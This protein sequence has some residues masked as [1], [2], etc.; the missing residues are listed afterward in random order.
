MATSGHG[1]RCSVMLWL[2]RSH[3]DPGSEIH[4]KRASGRAPARYMARRR[5]HRAEA[6]GHLD[7]TSGRYMWMGMGMGRRWGRSRV[8]SH[9]AAAHSRVAAETPG[10]RTP[11][12]TVSSI[13]NGCRKEGTWGVQGAQ[14]R[15]GL[16]VS[17]SGMGVCRPSAGRGR[18]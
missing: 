13:Q 18:G 1:R 14:G 7:G 8:L 3:P 2:P 9:P 16:L 12:P 6:L 10:C 5:T 15:Q 11:L 17:A 4:G